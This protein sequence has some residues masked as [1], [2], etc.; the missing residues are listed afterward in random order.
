MNERKSVLLVGTCDT[1]GD[2]IGFMRD[3]IES[4]NVKCLVMDIGLMKDPAIRPDITR[5]EVAAASGHTLENLVAQAQA[6][7]YE[8]SAEEL[9]IG[10][11]KFMTDEL[12]PNGA[13]DGVIA[14][15]G[16]MGTAITLK[17]LR[18][19]PIG[20]PK[21]LISTVALSDYVHPVFVQSDIMLVQPIS[22]FCSLNDWSKRDLQRAAL[23]M[24]SI[25]GREKPLE[26]GPWVGITCTGWTHYVPR[27]K[28]QLEKTGYKV[29]ISHSV[30]MQGSIMEQLIRQGVIKGFLDLCP[31]ELPHE[32][33]GASCNSTHRMEAASETGIP[34]IVSPGMWGLFT[35]PTA[36]MPRWAAEGRFTVP[37]NEIL[38]T[39]K[40]TL[41]EMVASSKLMASRLNKSSGPVAV[42]VPAQGF[43]HYDR[44]GKMYDNPE[45]RE[46]FMEVMRSHLK[47]AIELHILDCHINDSEYT[48]RIMALAKR[49]FGGIVVA[50]DS[51]HKVVNL[52][53]FRGQWE[54]P[55]QDVA[56]P[57]GLSLRIS[58]TS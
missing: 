13:I 25:V 14:I 3:V 51:V 38:G 28:E 36:D 23:S 12:V 42:V 52:A 5:Q 57:A 11:G 50:K 58:R 7:R 1:K 27:L 22:D 26:D 54:A 43:H 30:S 56:E 55:Q 31:F 37:H 46:A 9:A 8:A 16:S 41:D 4:E 32:V 35:M 2:E 6:G 29:S 48:D 15:G 45:G 18:S 53:P 24:A 20:F 34:Q 21:M 39:A 19:L 10:A 47:P 17:A 44:I 40:M 49:L 33:A